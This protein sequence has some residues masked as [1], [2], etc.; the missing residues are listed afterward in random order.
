MMHLY[1][2]VYQSERQ[3]ALLV[4][5]TSIKTFI[6]ASVSANTVNKDILAAFLQQRLHKD[7]EDEED[8]EDGPAR[9]QRRPHASHGECAHRHGMPGHAPAGPRERERAR[10]FCVGQQVRGTC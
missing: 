1:A 4:M 2:E 3:R 10:G 7:E 6:R 8:E 5:C 9:L